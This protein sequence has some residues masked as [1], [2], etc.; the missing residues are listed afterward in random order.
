[1][2]SLAFA[3]ASTPAFAQSSFKIGDREVQAHGSI[4]QGFVFST[5]NNFLTMN[6]RGGSG[7]MTG[8][9]SLSPL[10]T[11]LG[12]TVRRRRKRAGR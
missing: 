3:M 4:Q 8:G 5:G 7:A 6:T 1:M 11:Y 10:R 2:A 9:F 12:R